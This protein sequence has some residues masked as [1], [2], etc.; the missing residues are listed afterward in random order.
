MKKHPS[1]NS[2]TST[3]HMGIFFGSS[4]HAELF[5]LIPLAH[6]IIPKGTQ[7]FLKG[8]LEL[9]LTKAKN[10]WMTKKIL[11]SHSLGVCQPAPEHQRATTTTQVFE[12][13]VL[14]SYPF[15]FCLL[16]W[17]LLFWLFFEF[18]SFFINFSQS[19]TYLF[20][21]L[22]ASFFSNA[23]WLSCWVF[24][25]LANIYLLM[26]IAHKFVFSLHYLFF[27]IS[28]CDCGSLITFQNLYVTV[29]M[30]S[31]TCL[32]LLTT[33]CYLHFFH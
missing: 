3:T 18:S 11:T 10:Q 4:K 2:Q 21:C 24:F 16:V 20:F 7:I 32:S 6:T 12:I 5:I 33:F 14:V 19:I 15:W 30:N 26:F 17:L 28:Y 1:P 31:L 27:V 13:Q 29:Y 25:M 22:F 9:P 23:C 8:I